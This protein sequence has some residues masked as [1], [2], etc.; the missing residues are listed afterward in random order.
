MHQLDLFNKSS[1]KKEDVLKQPGDPKLK[2]D[3]EDVLPEKEENIKEEK[4][5]QLI[6][7]LSKNSEQKVSKRGRKSFKEVN[8]DIALLEI[9][10]DEIL[11]QK[12]YY[13]ISEVSEWFHVNAS[14][15]RFWESEFDIL[16]PRKNRKGD[17]LFRPEDIKNLRVIYYLLRQQKYSIEGAKQFLKDNK[18]KAE[19]QTQLVEAL[20]KFRSFLLELRANL[21][22]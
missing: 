4:L 20:T 10:E 6:T 14:L 3:A 18:Q 15:I 16:K 21:G 1:D 17:R 22:A 5:K 8:L 2:N 11:F 9:P 13:S 7:P 19:L 12:Q